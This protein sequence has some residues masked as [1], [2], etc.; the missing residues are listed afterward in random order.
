L[1]GSAVLAAR[2]IGPR[3]HILVG[4]ADISAVGG[5]ARHVGAL[6]DV[7]VVRDADGCCRS[8]PLPSPSRDRADKPPARLRHWPTLSTL[9]V[10]RVLPPASAV[11]ID[12]TPM[13]TAK[14]VWD[15]RLEL[16]F[17]MISC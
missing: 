13:A 8:T 10:E 14:A 7:L 16:S 15:L 6:S 1:I 17:I 5:I 2:H 3:S 12:S 4:D 9:P 11:P